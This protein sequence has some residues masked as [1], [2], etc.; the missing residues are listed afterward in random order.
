MALAL[1]PVDRPVVETRRKQQTSPTGG[2]QER[3]VWDRAPWPSNSRCEKTRSHSRDR[4]EHP[5]F[6]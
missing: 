4:S 3:P 1:N 5:R 6:S 2:P